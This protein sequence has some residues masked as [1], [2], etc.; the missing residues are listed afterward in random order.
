MRKGLFVTFEGCDGSGKTTQINYL[1]QYCMDLGHK[2]L[3]TREPGGTSISENIRAVILDP[4][5]KELAP[6]TEALLYAASRA[7]HVA[8]VI[9]PALSEGKIVLCDRYIDS[10]IAY[11]GYGRDLGDEVRIINEFAIQGLS[12]NITFF[13]DIKPSMGLARIEKKGDFDRIEKEAIDFHEKVYSGYMELIKNN[14]QRFIVVDGSAPMDIL[15]SQI[16]ELFKK[17]LSTF[18]YC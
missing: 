2:V 7:Q 6:T 8:E 3:L 11:Q 1:A 17:W 10:S 18:N 14:P 9:K 13:L 4:Q 16:R 15:A 5:N 12:P